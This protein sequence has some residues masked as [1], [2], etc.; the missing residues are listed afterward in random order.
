MQLDEIDIT[1]NIEY[2]YSSTEFREDDKEHTFTETDKT[3]CNCFF[4]NL[5]VFKSIEGEDILT[6]V[7]NFTIP[8]SEGSEP[9]AVKLAHKDVYNPKNVQRVF[10][11]VGF[12]GFPKIFTKKGK[13]FL[14]ELF[15]D[16]NF[17]KFKKASVI[18][19]TAID[20]EVETLL[21][22]IC[23]LFTRDF[24]SWYS[25]R[26]GLCAALENKEDKECLAVKSIDI[27][28]ILK[29][30]KITSDISVI[31][32]NINKKGLKLRKTYQPVANGVRCWYF[33]I[34]GLL[35]FGYSADR[36]KKIETVS[37]TVDNVEDLFSNTEVPISAEVLNWK[38]GLQK[39]A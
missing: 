33:P 23:K 20:I 11:A 12:I 39:E 38:T 9:F 4:E 29:S 13:G 2:R 15:M 10:Q 28:E 32:R 16:F 5:N 31:A 30:L 8:D 25:G 27:S 37:E 3:K 17:G 14:W 22:S 18:E 24:D 26:A 34:E 21:T 6:P 35:P 7:W 1:N 19:T 36:S